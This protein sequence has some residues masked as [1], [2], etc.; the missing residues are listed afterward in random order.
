MAGHDVLDISIRSLDLL[1]ANQFLYSRFEAISSGKPLEMPRPAPGERD[2]LPLYA[3]WLREAL[4]YADIE[5][6]RWRS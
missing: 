6:K 3:G 5:R 1:T 2:K 4:Q